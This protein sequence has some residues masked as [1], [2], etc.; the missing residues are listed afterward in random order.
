MG[1]WL[2]KAKDELDSQKHH[3]HWFKRDMRE[4]LEQVAEDLHEIRMVQREQAIA[5][6]TC[7]QE[8]V[9]AIQALADKLTHVK[10][11]FGTMVFEAR[12]QKE[13]EANQNFGNGTSSGTS[14]GEE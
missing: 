8:Q 5:E 11:Q 12:V 2:R 4:R 10:I 9:Q 7:Q 13:V 14:L 6:E 3:L 1:R